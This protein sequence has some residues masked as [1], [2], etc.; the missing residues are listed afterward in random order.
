MADRLAAPGPWKH[1]DAGK[2][3]RARWQASVIL[4]AA[5]GQPFEDVIELLGLAV[6][7]A[8]DRVSTSTGLTARE[9]RRQLVGSPRPGPPDR[10][11]AGRL[12]RMMLQP[13][14]HAE[15]TIARSGRTAD[16]ELLDDVELARALRVRPPTP[17]SPRPAR[18]PLTHLSLVGGDPRLMRRLGAR[19]VHLDVARAMG[20]PEVRDL[21]ARL[22]APQAPQAPDELIPLPARLGWVARWLPGGVWTLD[23]LADV[24]RLAGLLGLTPI[25]IA[26][27]LSPLVAEC[28]GLDEPAR[29]KVDRQ[30]L[31]R[32][33]TGIGPFVAGMARNWQVLHSQGPKDTPLAHAWLFA[34]RTPRSFGLHIA[35]AVGDP[36]PHPDDPPAE[37]SR[38][39][40]KSTGRRRKD[41]LSPSAILATIATFHAE[42]GHRPNTGVWDRREKRPWRSQVHRTFPGLPFDLIVS[43]ASGPPPDAIPTEGDLRFCPWCKSGLNYLDGWTQ[44]APQRWQVAV[45]CK[46]CDWRATRI[47][48]QSRRPALTV[49]PESAHVAAPAA[50]PEASLQPAAPSPPAVVQAP[51]DERDVPP[52]HIVI[53][54]IDP[55]LGGDGRTVD[56]LHRWHAQIPAG[57]HWRDSLG[58]AIARLEAARVHLRS[59]PAPSR[60]PAWPTAR[61]GSGLPT[62]SAADRSSAPRSGSPRNESPSVA[63]SIPGSRA[64]HGHA[65]RTRAAANAEPSEEAAKRSRTSRPTPTTPKAVDRSPRIPSDPQGSARFGADELPRRNGGAARGVLARQAGGS[66]ALEAHVQPLLQRVMPSAG[67]HEHAVER[68]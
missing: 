41:D 13:R 33:R 24:D 31:R 11:V 67:E 38:Y 61:R 37:V 21:A 7:D 1:L 26:G 14:W 35:Y 53:R 59:P 2:H 10:D 36:N 16:L 47:L 48:D 52:H 8:V 27:R 15:I 66:L 55:D 68:H 58:D 56:D 18:I 20:R 64:S 9:V 49:E 65:R 43:L 30:T 19:C 12:A 44:L 29:R 3:I 63:R 23:G 51:I 57:D 4:R 60:P 42:A 25:D 54:S 34:G 46:D 32:L 62:I 6:E 50:E 39:Q 40:P 22:L 5:I 45:E 28:D 17:P